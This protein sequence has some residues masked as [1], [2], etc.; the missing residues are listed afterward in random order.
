M[1][2]TASIEDYAVNTIARRIAGDIV[3]S[4]NPGN[5]LK[6]WREYFEVSQQAVARTMGVSPSVVSDYEKGRRQPGSKFIQ[7]FVIA[8]LTIDRARGWPKLT[9]LTRTLGVPPGVIVDMRDFEEPLSIEEMLELVEGILLAPS[10]P[11]EKKIYGYTVIDSI[12]AIA[13]L[14]GTQF[15]TLLGGTPER[16][17][18]FTG[19]QAG[20]SPMVAVRVSPVKPSLVVIHGPRRHVDPL[21]VKL[22]QLDGVP[23]ILSLAQTVEELVERL[24]RKS[25]RDMDLAISGISSFSLL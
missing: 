10:Y 14:S 20:R 25:V 2:N 15:Y 1:S 13:S 7:R 12:R 18:I 17:V 6:K 8:L 11:P 23:F 9:R 3:L 21:A 4:D 22:A 5:S 16:A 24:R 19:V